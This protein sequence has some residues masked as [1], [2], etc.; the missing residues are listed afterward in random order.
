MKKFV[1]TSIWLLCGM[2]MLGLAGCGGGAEKL[3]KDVIGGTYYL[4]YNFHYIAEKRKAKGSVAN[5]TGGTGHAML[6]YGSEVTI[7]SYSKG[8]IL[9]DTKSGTEINVLAPNKFLGS[10]S[11]SDYINQIL[12]KSPV[13]YTGL[14]DAD[15]KGIKEGKAYPGMTKKG[16]MIALGYPCPHMT[17]SPEENTWTY[18]TNRFNYYQVQFANSVVTSTGY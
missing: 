12:S 2:V 1:Q 18:W 10:M 5:Y 9:T 4:N 7:K 6:A 13:S 17:A 15:T 11:L 16:V 8:F 3:S 14:S